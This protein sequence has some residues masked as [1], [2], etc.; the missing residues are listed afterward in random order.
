MEQNI[1]DDGIVVGIDLGTTNSLIATF[2][3]GKAIII[4]N[5]R[6]E[7]STPSVVGVN[8]N[9]KI[10]VGKIAKERL[11]TN[12]E[13][14]TSLFKRDMGTNKK[15]K[16]GKKNFSPEELSCFILRQLISD[17]EKYLNKKVVEAVISVPAYFN[18][19]QRAATK[20]A[21]T[22]AGV[23][24]ER[25]IN[26]PSAAALALREKDAD[27]TF[28]V[29][30][31]GGGTLDVS[32]VESFDNIINICSI[33]GNNFLGG[34][35]FDK[36][37]VNA[38]CAENNIDQKSLTQQESQILLKAAEAAKIKLQDVNHAYIELQIKD[39][40][41]EFDLSNE[42]L[43]SLSTEIFAQI[44]KPI[45]AAVKD[46]K[47]SVS[48]ISKCILV[49]GSCN[50]PVVLDFL[51]S[52]LRVPVANNDS[53]DLDQLVAVGLGVYVGIKQREQVVKD[54]VLT[55]ICPFSLNTGIHNYDNPDRLITSTI[56]PRNTILPT[57][58]TIPLYTVNLGQTE[59]KVDITQGEQFYSDENILLGS[60]KT[61]IPHNVKEYEKIEVT[62]YYDINAILI[63]KVKVMSTGE[64]QTLA[65]S[66]D[67]HTLTERQTEKYIENIL[68]IKLGHYTRRDL[69]LEKAKR[70]Y[71]EAVHDMQR[72]D[73]KH[74]I[75]N[76]EQLT[77]GGSIKKTNETLDKFEEYLNYYENAQE[78]DGIFNDVH[79]FLKLVKGGTDE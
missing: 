15:V 70:M 31:F 23:K 43:Y 79:T 50:M 73:F 54:L 24:V 75:L 41:I 25:L 60:V 11:I 16:L 29:F 42:R 58:K 17:A 8:E 19:K 55:D 14:T 21:G 53:T 36:A 64:E 28:I 62:Y 68:N 39:K 40:K 61:K 22:L 9:N 63:V 78:D 59:I 76:L 26:E 44:K 65:L 56:I 35:D 38:I 49:G 71:T 34:M 20:L 7:Y 57:S 72:E 27:E 69:L 45:K 67:G 74:I 32:I 52:L 37:I 13:L 33:S 51:E 3:D 46:S 12:P 47:L 6:G 5:E 66:G 48:E 2:I 4:P 77:I 18:A 1:N 30:D 10:L